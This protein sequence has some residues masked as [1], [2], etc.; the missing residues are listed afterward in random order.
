MAEKNI[1]ET[2][3]LQIYDFFQKQHKNLNPSAQNFILTFF[4]LRKS[5]IFW[6]NPGFYDKK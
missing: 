5:I 2:I 4:N 1:N 3:S 6:S